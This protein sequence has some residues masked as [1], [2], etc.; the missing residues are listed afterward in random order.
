[1]NMDY[2][3]LDRYAE[4]YK[5]TFPSFTI[6]VSNRGHG[7]LFDGIVISVDNKYIYNKYNIKKE[8]KDW[9]DWYGCILIYLYEKN[10]MYLEVYDTRDYGSVA[11]KFCDKHFIGNKLKTDDEYIRIIDI[12]IKK[13]IHIVNKFRKCNYFQ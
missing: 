1:M 8:Y 3:K 10:S 2:S 11:D 12:G 13:Y 7:H 4:L 9:F 5:D 6:V